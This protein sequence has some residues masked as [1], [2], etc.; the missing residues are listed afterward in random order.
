MDVAARASNA[1]R[2][3]EKRPMVHSAAN[4]LIL[5]LEFSFALALFIGPILAWGNDG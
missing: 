2:N 5:W 3:E 1:P 4:F